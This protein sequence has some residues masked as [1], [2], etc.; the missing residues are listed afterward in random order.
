MAITS[1]QRTLALELLQK[2][3]YASSEDEYTRCYQQLK[4][5]VPVQVLEYYD[6]NWHDIRCE[7]VEGLKRQEMNFLMSTNN[8]LEVLNHKIKSVCSKYSTLKVFFRDLLSCIDTLRSERDHRVVV[9]VQKQPLNRYPATSTEGQIQQVL[10]PYAAKFVLHQLD[11]SSH[12]DV[13]EEQQESGDTVL[14]ATDRGQ[15]LSVT[16]E[17]CGCGFAKSMSLPCCH[18]L[19]A[20]QFRQL[21]VFS[22]DLCAVRWHKDFYVSRHRVMVNSTPDG[23]DTCT[24]TS[25][26]DTRHILK[27]SDKYR[28]AMEV[29]KELCDLLSDAPMRQFCNRVD[30]LKAVLA[31]WKDNKEV[32]LTVNDDSCASEADSGEEDVQS[33]TSN[34][35]VSDIGSLSLTADSGDEGDPQ[36]QPSISASSDG[37]HAVEFHNADEQLEEQSESTLGVRYSSYNVHYTYVNYLYCNIMSACMLTITFMIYQFV[38]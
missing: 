8:R 15:T 21:D 4:S 12:I 25:V 10:T 17:K 36:P 16:V 37:G 29:S 7:W 30:F 14:L 38:A 32:S 23:G 11:K 3:S 34:T 2:L 6:Q 28:R 1:T 19:K 9:I 33:E 26:H 27:S 31:A 35:V 5:T 20:R 24:V 18:I 22:R 13:T